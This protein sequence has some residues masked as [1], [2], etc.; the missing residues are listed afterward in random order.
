[1]SKRFS[2][3]EK[4]K[5]A[6]FID[7]SPQAKILFL[8]FCDC[9]DLAGFYERHDKT[10]S[11][12]TGIILTELPEVYKELEKSVVLDNGII[13][14]KNFIKHQKNL[15]LNMINNSHKTI[16]ELLIYRA[17]LF[18]SYYEQVLG[19][20]LETI[21]GL[22]GGY[23]GVLS[24]IGKDK[25]NGNG[26][27]KD[28]MEPTTEISGII[29]KNKFLSNLKTTY[30]MLNVDSEILACITWHKNKGREV[31]SWDRAIGNWLKIAYEKMGVSGFVKPKE[32]LPPDPNCK[33]CSG[34]G[35]V[36]NGEGKV[37]FCKCVKEKK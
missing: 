19:L 10:I 22:Q 26:N 7:L 37:L 28:R 21:R 15:P 27:G 2:D 33:A 32:Y 3:T 30:P 6:W 35:K 8:F 31:K 24:P 16:V 14:V 34:T 13:W 11:F 23:K 1:M 36:L 4:W 20:S 18:G 12:H 5:D 9:C 29:F 25:D 17:D